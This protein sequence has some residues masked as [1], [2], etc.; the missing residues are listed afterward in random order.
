MFMNPFPRAFGLNIGDR[1]IKAVRLHNASHRRRHASYEL[2]AA[3]STAL[4]EGLIVNGIIQEP[5]KVRGYISH[6]LRGRHG[7]EKPIGSAWVAA[8]LP[9]IQGFLKR[10]DIDKEADDIIPEDVQYAAK[11][12]VPFGDEEYYIDWQIMRRNEKNSTHIL[13]GAVSK[14]VADMYT[15][16][17]ESLG[18]GVIALEIETL[19]IARCLV[20]ADKEYGDEAR[21]LLDIG[22]SRSSFTVF[23]RDEIQFSV[24]LPFSGLLVTE[25]VG[26]RLRIPPEEAE[27]RKK[28]VGLSYAKSNERVWSAVNE[29]V[30]ILVS[31]IRRAITFYASHFPGGNRITHITMCGGG[32]C[33]KRLDRVLSV[34]L[35]TEVRPGRV[36]KNLRAKRAISLPDEESPGYATAIGLALRAADNP[37]FER[38]TI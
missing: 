30:E 31:H 24:S 35:K 8:S 29:A 25:M 33:M 17:L 26:A 21:G 12:H 15:Y 20:T 2:V 3:R 38:D 11:K 36:W 14:Q 27:R 10:I 16:L 23:D 13:L 1:S 6:L 34:K 22:A 4:P 32:A 7:C 9:D 5:E 28:S 19:A 37:F 18:L